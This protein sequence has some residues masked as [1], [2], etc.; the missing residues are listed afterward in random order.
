MKKP[1]FFNN[2]GLCISNGSMVYGLNHGMFRWAPEWVK[3]SICY[4]WNKVHCA[5]VGHDTFGYTAYVEHLF[6]GPPICSVCCAR[7][8]IDGRYPTHEEIENHNE[9]CKK[10]WKEVEA[11]WRLNNPDQP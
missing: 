4:A 6:P 1:E 8:K 3:N 11:T 7:L 9:L 5:F 10:R 2:T